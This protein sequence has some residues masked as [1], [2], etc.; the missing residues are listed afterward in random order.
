[1]RIICTASGVYTSWLY[2][3]IIAPICCEYQWP[4]RIC[5]TPRQQSAPTVDWQSLNFMTKF[6][7]MAISSCD[8]NNCCVVIFLHFIHFALSLKSNNISSSSGSSV[9]KST[10][11]TSAMP[12]S[13]VVSFPKIVSS[14][15]CIGDQ[16]QRIYYWSIRNLG[17]TAEFLATG[18]VVEPHVIFMQSPNLRSSKISR[19]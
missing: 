11:R 3:S 17:S 6:K 2:Q 18:F 10:T 8:A 9:I 14:F 13:V 19:T 15:V 7:S 16:R 4:S 5:M 12:L 1:M